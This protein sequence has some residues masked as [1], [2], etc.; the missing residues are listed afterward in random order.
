MKNTV[1]KRTRFRYALRQAASPRGRFSMDKPV[2]GIK[3]PIR[4]A[5]AVR[6]S[7]GRLRLCLPAILFFF[8]A[9]FGAAECY[10]QDVAEAARQ[11]R[12]RKESRHKKTKH[13]YT[14]EDLKRGQIL[15]PEDRAQIEAR[16][17]Q[18]APPTAQKPHEAID[19]QSLAPDAPL[20]DVARHFRKQK[21]SQKP[22]RSAEFHLPVAAA[23]AL[24]SPKPPVQPLPPPVS[25]PT[26]PRLV[27]PK[28]LVKRSP[29][30]RPNLVIAAPPRLLPSQPPAVRV[31]PSQPIALATQTKLQIV[32]VQ[33][34]DSLWRLAQL[35]LGQGHLWRDLLLVNPGIHD[36]NHIVAGS[37]IYVPAVVSALGTATNYTVRKGDSLW[38]IAQARF[39][40]GASWTC[41]AHA[42][43]GLLT[44]N[45]IFPGLVLVLP[46]GCRTAPPS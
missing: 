43:P 36:P 27:Q 45:L 17:N 20:G 28:P 4:P 30:A 37:Q 16:K 12:A 1:S 33:R 25:K 39:G 38:K 29:F 35:N 6:H 46:D 24:A 18:P 26:P 14:N 32:T 23:P 11:E 21:E 31:A 19:A 2:P 15:T 13:V 44:P 9:S 42:N 10:G 34:G 3:P 40:H 41:I 5:I 7:S 8:C 22:Q